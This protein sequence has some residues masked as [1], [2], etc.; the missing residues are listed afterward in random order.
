MYNVQRWAG[1]QTFTMK[2]EVTASLVSDNL[3]Q[4]VDQQICEKWRFTISSLSCEFPQISLTFF[5]E[6]FT[7]QAVQSVAHACT[8]NADNG[9]GFDF[10]E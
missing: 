6:I 7:G 9:L 10:L 3:I 5:Y 1:E 4:S 8:Q 2:S